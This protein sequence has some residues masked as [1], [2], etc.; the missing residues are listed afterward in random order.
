[1]VKL[2]FP[3]GRGRFSKNQNEPRIPVI[4]T[5]NGCRIKKMMLLDSGSTHIFLPLE[6]AEKLGFDKKKAKKG[7][8]V[9]GLMVSVDTKVFDINLIIGTA[10]QY[11]QLSNL[12]VSVL[13][14]SDDEDDCVLGI[15]PIFEKFNVYFKLKDYEIEMTDEN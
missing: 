6:L 5:K 9:K 8:P 14:K 1:M 11:K 13:M 2:I 15:T 12:E 3:F 4:L 10:G 7:N